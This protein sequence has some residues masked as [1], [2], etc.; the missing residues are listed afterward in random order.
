M[1]NTTIKVRLW[2]IGSVGLI[3]PHR[4]GVIYTNQTGGRGCSQPELKGFY[5]PLVDSQIDLQQVFFDYFSGPKWKKWC[6]RSKGIDKETAD[7]IDTVLKKSKFTH[8]LQVDRESLKESHEAWVRVI[9]NKQKLA[10]DLPVVGKLEKSWGI[11]T[12]EN[13][14]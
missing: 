12:W 1:I 11:L 5:V 7:Y 10:S 2:H 8:A 4:T 14:D 13:S 3:I 6:T 9:L